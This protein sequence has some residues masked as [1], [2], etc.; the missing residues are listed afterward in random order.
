MHQAV[1]ALVDAAAKFDVAAIVQIFGTD[2]E[3]ILFTDEPVR[4]RQRAADFAAQANEKRTVAVDPTDSNRVTLVVGR[5]AWPFPIPL[6][7]QGGKWSFDIQA[8]RQELLYRRIGANELDAISV[9]RGYVTAQSQYALQKREGY[10]VHQ[11]AQRI[12]STPGQQDGLA[13][14]NADGTWGGPVGENV[15][16]AIAQGYTNTGNPQPFHGYFF[17]VLK[18]QGPAAPLGAMNFVVQG[19]MIGGFALAAAPA[20]YEVTGVKTFIVGYDGIVYQ[21]DL[22]PKTLR[23]FQNMTLYNPDKTWQRTDDDW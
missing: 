1:V 14:Q 8:G 23:I 20:E 3:D 18:G 10:E 9:C 11:Y 19:A 12:L 16:R 15:A 22:G 7:K 17:K 6:V 4:D 13:W 2:A 5:E 21:K